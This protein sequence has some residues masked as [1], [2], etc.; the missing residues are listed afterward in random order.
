MSGRDQHPA[1]H[2]D[3][4]STPLAAMLL[5]TPPL[6]WLAQLIISVT[7]TSWSCFPRDVRAMAPLPGYRMA[8]LLIVLICA[9]L[10]AICT[11][12]AARKLAEIKDEK[13]GGH[14]HLADRGGGRTRF[15]ALWSVIL[16]VTF[17]VA[18]LITLVAFITVRP[19][20]G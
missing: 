15:L 19:C 9:G 2:A 1:P 5:F 20:A 10:A 18:T 8:A 11:A 6:A 12:I 13:E 3:K 16:G 14:H 4:L 17:T 7:L